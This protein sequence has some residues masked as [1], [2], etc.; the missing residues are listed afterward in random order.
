MPHPCGIACQERR[1]SSRPNCRFQAQ[2]F[3]SR[4][5]GEAGRRRDG[6][7]L[8]VP[9]YHSLL[10]QHGEP[11]NPGPLNSTFYDRRLNFRVFFRH[12]VGLRRRVKNGDDSGDQAIGPG[13]TAAERSQPSRHACECGI[14]ATALIRRPRPIRCSSGEPCVLEEAEGEPTRGGRTAP[15]QQSS[16]SV[17]PFQGGYAY[18]N[19]I[20][21]S[22]P[23]H[24]KA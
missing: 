2:W 7:R 20:E 19:D 23:L 1:P 15:R 21:R 10:P 14:A 13:R 17:I 16:Q 9:L 12:S 24:A 22:I 11:R 3:A 4:R 6:W 5:A 8:R 18:N